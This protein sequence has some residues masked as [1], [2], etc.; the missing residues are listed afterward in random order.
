M[1]NPDNTTFNMNPLAL[2]FPVGIAVVLVLLSIF[3][4]PSKEFIMKYIGIIYWIIIPVFT[5]IMGVCIGFANQ[6]LTCGTTNVGRAF[7]SG[8]PVLGTTM[9][10]IILT[11]FDSI[12]IFRIPVES[13][14]SGNRYS[15]TIFYVF[16]SILFGGV[17][18]GVLSDIC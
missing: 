7:L 2:S 3:I 15:S 18:G 4:I 16:W 8:L 1:S 13:V 5:Y 6:Y 14:F 10:A 9:I 11:W 17:I 12:R